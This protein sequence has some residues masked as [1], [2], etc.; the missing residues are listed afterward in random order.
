MP[1]NRMLS[2]FDDELVL[3]KRSLAFWCEQ[4]AFLT[5]T[6]LFDYAKGMVRLREAEIKQMIDVQ[7]LLATRRAA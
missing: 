6:E 5:D 2:Q 4:E 3:A 1:R 7:E